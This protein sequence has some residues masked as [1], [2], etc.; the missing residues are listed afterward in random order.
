MELRKFAEI[1]WSAFSGCD[2]DDPQIGDFTVTEIGLE[3]ESKAPGVIIL[4]NER[5]QIHG[6]I[7]D[8]AENEFTLDKVFESSAVAKIFAAGM[9]ESY[10]EWYLIN[11]LH[12]NIM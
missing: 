8:E 11:V 5:I 7:E 12:F 2:S 9:K 3:G 10:S 6:I 1:D 4:D